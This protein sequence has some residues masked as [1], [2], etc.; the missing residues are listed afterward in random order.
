MSYTPVLLWLPSSLSLLLR[1]QYPRFGKLFLLPCVW[2]WWDSQLL[3]AL[4]NRS[5]QTTPTWSISVSN[6]PGNRDW[7]REWT[8][9]PG[10]PS[11]SSPRIE[12][13]YKEPFSCWGC[14]G[15]SDS[16]LPSSLLHS[17]M[18]RRIVCNRRHWGAPGILIQGVTEMKQKEGERVNLDGIG[19]AAS[20][21]C[22]KSFLNFTNTR[23]FLRAMRANKFLCGLS[24]F[25]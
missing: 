13:L 4:P 14:A 19:S 22:W 2:F 16:Y 25:A 15:T 9:D 17:P 10:E 3:Q 12:K 21:N 7:S 23:V 1:K 24:W 5:K 8:Y 18:W 20:T 11:E 6:A